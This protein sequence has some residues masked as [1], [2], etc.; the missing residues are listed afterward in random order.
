MKKLVL[1]I[2]L[3]F[4]FCPPS[5]EAE[6]KIPFTCRVANLPPGRCG[7][8]VLETLARYQGI[9]PLYGLAAEHASNARPKDL[10][11]ALAATGVKYR[12]QPRGNTSTE[13]LQRAIR[14]NRGALVGFRPLTSGGRG[15][16]VT[17]VDFG[18]QEVRFLDP[19]EGANSPQSMKLSVFLKRWDGFALVLEASQMQKN[20]R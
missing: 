2:S 1:V 16:I 4:F 3:S 15:H 8:C 9:E 10:E 13:I 18:A 14:E 12:I 11:R 6:V 5:A 7:W 20:V 17:L 19:N